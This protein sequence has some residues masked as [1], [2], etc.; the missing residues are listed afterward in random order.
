MKGKIY[1]IGT[2]PGSKDLIAERALKAIEES[3]VIAGYGVYTNLISDLIKDKEMI[4]TPMKQEVQ[5]CNMAIEKAIE[6]HTVSL[7]SS[8]DAGVYGMAGLLLELAE[9]S[10]IEIEVIPGISAVLA[11]AARLGAPLTH[12]FAVISLSD[13]LTPW[14]KIEKRLY[15][16]AMSEF[17]IAIYNP[18]SKKRADYLEKACNIMAPFIHEN[19]VCG[20][21]K[22]CERENEEY[23][24]ILFKH[25]K[26]FQ[27]DMFTIIIIGNSTTKLINNKMVTPRGYKGV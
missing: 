12:D 4:V 14:E 11:A 5:R 6:G 21:V 17:I 16:A 1:I 15:Y 19:T 3:S 20:Y 26:S 13:L 27:A 23:G 9:N 25:L 24:T 18:Q 8:G 22:N 7:I 2:G 10:N